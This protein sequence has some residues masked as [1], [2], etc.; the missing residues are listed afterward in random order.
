MPRARV[1]LERT[2]R[3]AFIATV[4]CGLPTAQQHTVPV[5]PHLQP[6][7]P[8]STSLATTVAAGNCGCKT[9][10]G[11]GDGGARVAQLSE[12]RGSVSRS[13]RC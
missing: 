12:Y 5:P 10:G 1:R 11:G 6:Q 2:N 7:F 3:A 8:R 13:V 9:V 4:G